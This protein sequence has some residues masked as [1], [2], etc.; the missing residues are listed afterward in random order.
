MAYKNLSFKNLRMFA[1][2]ATLLFPS[3]MQGAEISGPGLLNL[4]REKDQ[5]S[6]AVGYR[7][8]FLL[9]KQAHRFDPNQGVVIEDC[10]ATWTPEGSFAM[11]KTNYY[12]KDIPVFALPG[13]GNYRGWDYDHDGNLIV[14]R[15]VE[16][17]ILFT[18][19]KNDRIQISKALRIDPNGKLV[20]EGSSHTTLHRYP[21]GNRG[22][23]YEFDK[24]QLATGRGFSTKDLGSITSVKTLSSGL[25]QVTAHRP[26]VPA[27]TWELT[28]D[29]NLDWLVRKAILTR[30][31]ENKPTIV[32]T[33]SGIM[34][35]DGIK[36]SKYGT[37]RY[38]SSPE[39][40]FEVTDISKVVGPNKLYEEVLSRLNS[41]LPSGASIVDL[42]GEKP[43]RT[44]VK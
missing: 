5:T 10:Q 13:T 43:V 31:R 35:K 34:M 29:P 7:I 16:S 27:L 36:V 40:S 19:E 22:N 18:P 8:S 4:L 11:K 3:I 42:R 6:K 33:S 39:V 2:I 12:E 23:M 15:D 30:E 25:M 14:W 20:R 28:T 9:T 1:L 24:L 26:G 17:Y 44:T 21:I 38:S 37:Y 32:V 41:P